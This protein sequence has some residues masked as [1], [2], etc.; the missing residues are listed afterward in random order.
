MKKSTLTIRLDKELDSL[1]SR[2]SKQTGKSK[3]QIAREALHRQFRI[4][5]FESLRRKT[6]PFAEARDYLTDEDVLREIS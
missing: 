6:M 4:E 2:V 1:L 5:Q 3:S